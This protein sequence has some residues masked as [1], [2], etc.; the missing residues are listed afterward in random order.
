M[1]DTS[2]T[3]DPLTIFPRHQDT[4][5][6]Q[7][8]FP[9]YA[10]TYLPADIQPKISRDFWRQQIP[11]TIMTPKVPNSILMKDSGRF[12]NCFGYSFDDC[13]IS[14]WNQ[15][16]QDLLNQLRGTDS[17]R[18]KSKKSQK[19]LSEY[20]GD[21]DKYIC[22]SDSTSRW[23]PDTASNGMGRVADLISFPSERIER[24]SMLTDDRR[25]TVLR[26]LD[27]TPGITD[28]ISELS[29]HERINAFN[30]DTD[31]ILYEMDECR[32]DISEL[33]SQPVEPSESLETSDESH[34]SDLPRMISTLEKFIQNPHSG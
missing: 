27:W 24:S 5:D 13:V 11:G 30:K 19:L 26:G 29:T 12:H 33:S 25:G 34:M 21:I 1:C 15:G 6:G 20:S 10:F 2:F 23:Q 4:E 17:I 14:Q 7:Y 18:S 28:P 16:L 22:Y 8:I 3:P 9:D 32:L 31:K